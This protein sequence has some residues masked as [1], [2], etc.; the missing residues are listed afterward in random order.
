MKN[1]LKLAAFLAA[2]ALMGWVGLYLHWHFRIG[3]A[4]RTL[5][6]QPPL[7]IGDGGS[8]SS[9]DA[10]EILLSGGCRSLSYLLAALDKANNQPLV[11]DMYLKILGMSLP[12]DLKSQ[13]PSQEENR[14]VLG[15]LS[16][17][18]RQK[19]DRLRAWWQA[20]ESRIHQGWKVWSSK[21]AAE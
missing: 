10:N 14:I 11:C 21:C 15:D 16:D 8:S 3:G 13:M 12:A 17:Q 4:V 7:V 5:A 20:N 6:N 18:R 1:I 2:L 9:G 19:I